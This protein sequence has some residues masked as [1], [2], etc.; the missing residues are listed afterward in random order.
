M[1]PGNEYTAVA[2]PELEWRLDP[3]FGTVIDCNA[4]LGTYLK[5]P[6]VTYG[7]SGPFT[8]SFWLQVKENSG[9]DLNYAFS[10]IGPT[11]ANIDD[12]SSQVHLYLPEQSH[13]HYGV[14]R[15]I[16]LDT[17][18]PIEDPTDPTYLDSDGCVVDPDCT[19]ASEFRSADPADGQWHQ[20][21]LSTSPN[22]GDKGFR[23]FIDGAEAAAMVDGNDYLSNLG[24]IHTATGGEALDLGGDIHL[25]S[26]VDENEN[27]FLSGSITQL[28][29]WN[30]ALTDHQIQ[31]LY[32][33][34][35]FTPF[36]RANTP[37][38]E[39][40][41][42]QGMTA[43]GACQSPCTE[44]MGERSCLAPS[45]ELLPCNVT[46]YVATMASNSSLSEANAT[47]SAG[48]PLMDTV[49]QSR[50]EMAKDCVSECESVNGLI[51]CRTATGELRGCLMT[52]STDGTNETAA[53]VAYG[54]GS[55]VGSADPILIDG[56]PL[57]SANVI[58]GLETI[59][60]CG[61]GYICFPL[62]QKQL[63]DALGTAAP[64]EDALGGPGSVGICAYASSNV[65]LPPAA[66]VPP[67]DAFFPLASRSLESYPLGRYKT[68]NAG[69]SIVEDPVF[70]AALRCNADEKDAIGIEPVPYGINGSFAINIWVRPDNMSGD[71]FAYLFSHI[72]TAVYGSESIGDNGFGPNQVQLLLPE[73]D[74]PSYG[75]A[76]TFVR[77]GND[78]YVGAESE[79]YVDSGN[80]I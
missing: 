68:L 53:G 16:V 3:V 44:Y 22:E 76:R 5:I 31:D 69:A 43:Q 72:N 15:A 47:E 4:S 8:I 79:S 2:S 25:C 28:K 77:D 26:R 14:L 42:P 30:E 41:S 65:M 56:Q 46:S 49:A 66:V 64:K 51:G 20:I 18:D 58:P 10:Q 34:D 70:G 36:V 54:A 78:Y 33:I 57:C 40:S 75:V 11:G 24:T 39:F 12:A 73:E 74:H 32:D 59:S 55:I 48:S 13:P 9:S 80:M 35:P 29:I 19:A 62:T 6:N 71:A 7:A 27:R 61:S 38:T 37:E 1:E 45:G 67:A 63:E 21:V 23:I 50:Y 52:P 60:S 17:T